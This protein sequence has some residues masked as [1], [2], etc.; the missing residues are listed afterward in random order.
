MRILTIISRLLIGSLFIVSGLIKAN[1]PLGFSYK[2]NDY[3]AASVLNM[4]WLDSFA[5]E[6][7]IFICVVEIVLGVAVLLGSKMKVATWSLLGL[8]IFFTF[9]TGLTA[10][11]NWLFENNESA[12]TLFLEGLFGFVIRE[13]YSYMKDCGCFGDALKLT[14]WQSFLKDVVLLVVLIPTFI[15]RKKIESNTEKEDMIM[16]PIAVALVALFSLGVVSWGFPILF[17]IF[18]LGILF[19][20]KKWVKMPQLDWGMAV[21]ATI[22]A[23]WFSIYS[24]QHLPIRDYRPYAV[25]KSLPDGI[26]CPDGAPQDIYEDKWFY[27]VNG[28]VKEF[29]T[30]DAPWKI[31]GAEYVDRETELIFKGCEPPIHDFVLE[32]YDGNDHTDEILSEP[33]ILLIV[34]YDITAADE[35]VQAAINALNTAAQNDPKGGPYVYGLSA[36]LH[37]NVE[38]FKTKHKTEFD[39]LTA[40][41]TALKTVI[42]SNPGIVLLKK[43]VVAGK[44]HHNDLPSYETLRAEY[45]N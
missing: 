12:T 37:D 45:L 14:P 18:L 24:L 23:T 42:R 16:L 22:V 28:E 19:A 6:L 38:A 35:D 33:A 25:G 10:V 29:T 43:G 15:W 3:F 4:P 20:M 27:R 39:F 11:A 9:L 36:S 2:L 13:D 30:A 21:V 31:A 32:D 26:K 1:D 34:T 7:S 44:W 40:D 17:S 8:M 41:A 5:L